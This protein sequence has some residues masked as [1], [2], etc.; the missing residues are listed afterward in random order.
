MRRS[1]LPRCRGAAAAQ[2]RF[3]GDFRA[4]VTAARVLETD[5]RTE[6]ASRSLERPYL[7]ALATTSAGAYTAASPAR[8]SGAGDETAGG[9]GRAG[10][11]IRDGRRLRAHARRVR[12]CRAHRPDD[13]HGAHPG[14]DGHREGAGRARHP[15][16]EPPEPPSIR[17]ASIAAPSPRRSSRASC[18]ATSR[19]RSRGRSP[20]S[21]ASS[22][23]RRGDVLPRR[24][25]RG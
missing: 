21:E 18:S 11:A 8:G 23:R 13:E 2:D 15:L 7:A 20:T 25:R 16:G 9:G 6:E 3:G 17:D 24:D 5:V 14:R 22:K 10:S 1:G 4:L 12:D 19:A